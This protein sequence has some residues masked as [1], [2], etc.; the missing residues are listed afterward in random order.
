MQL[1]PFTSDLKAQVFQ[2][3]ENQPDKRDLWDWQYNGNPRATNGSSGVVL[4]IDGKV[5]GFKGSMHARLKIGTSFVDAL[6]NIDTYVQPALRGK[7]LGREL[8]KHAETIGPVVLAFGISE[9]QLPIYEKREGWVR[10]R[11]A[12]EFFFQNRLYSSKDLLK[13]V[14]QSCSVRRKSRPSTCYSIVNVPAREIP[15]DSDQIWER[16]QFEYDKIVVRDYEY[17]KWKYSDHPNQPYRALLAYGS[18]KLIAIAIYRSSAQTGRF[19]DY[20]GPARDAGLKE[21]LIAS[22][23]AACKDSAK[24]NIITTDKELKE[25]LKRYGFRKYGDGPAFWV[26]ANIPAQHCKEGWFLMA[27]D[28]DGDL[29]DAMEDRL[30]IRP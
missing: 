14:I 26:Y 4:L 12:Q 15:M 22:F 11:E 27:G 2:L 6:W 9:M 24:L 8:M 28:S 3:L 20:I 16:V 1:I 23:M 5:A 21:Q 19:V 18:D 7:G 17:L 25:A 13:I 10:N 29:I 30:C